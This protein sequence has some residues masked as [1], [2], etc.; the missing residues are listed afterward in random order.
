M[1]EPAKRLAFTDDP[2]HVFESIDALMA[3][4]A[5]SGRTGARSV[6]SFSMDTE[7]WAGFERHLDKALAAEVQRSSVGDLYTATN[8][9][10]SEAHA[11][12]KMA[13]H[14]PQRAQAYANC[15]AT[16][17]AGREFGSD[18]TTPETMAGH[19]HRAVAWYSA[20]HLIDARVTRADIDGILGM[21]GRGADRAVPAPPPPAPRSAIPAET[22][23]TPTTA[24][25]AREVIGNWLAATGQRLASARTTTQHLAA[26]MA[27]A[28]Q[29]R[30]AE[31]TEAVKARVARMR[32]QQAR[33]PADHPS[34]A[35]TAWTPIAI[36]G[37]RM[38]SSTFGTWLML[39]ALSWVALI[40][41]ALLA[42]PFVGPFGLLGAMMGGFWAVPLWGTVFGFLGMGAA[43]ASTLNHMGFRQVEADDWLATTTTRLAAR[44][45]LPPPQVGTIPQF[46]AFAMGTDHRHATVAIGRPLMEKLSRDEVAAVIGHELGHVV[47]GDMRKMMLMRTFQNA[48][49][50]YMVAQGAK[51][52]MR[53]VIGWAAEL[54]VLAFSRRREYW[55]D[56]VGAALTSKDAMIGALR[57]IDA[58]PA[59]TSAEQTYA[60]FMFR[61][62]AFSTHPSVAE[63]I[64][65]L[66]KESYLRLLPVK[67]ERVAA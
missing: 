62:S 15:I 1:A 42:L 61:G 54:A 24:E 19:I 63:R 39:V 31:E 4:M 60:R 35:T 26:E 5:G 41:G 14:G 47:S 45:D 64:A 65:A 6:A 33:A 11:L 56:A 3:A 30:L 27:K 49:V 7:T 16:I 8:R 53:W 50:W 32:E 2:S 18:L 10:V 25:K 48:C 34:G 52:F 17:E 21:A 29:A 20:W 28:R 23:V 57:K 38:R 67:P 22:P 13:S 46:N 55:A 12:L 40:W 51:Q 9:I 43:K 36:D 37:N 66:E 59:L 58:A 44:L